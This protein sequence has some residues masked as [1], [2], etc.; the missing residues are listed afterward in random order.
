MILKKIKISEFIKDNSFYSSCLVP[1]FPEDIEVYKK[2]Q[3]NVLLEVD[4]KQPRN[5]LL[6]RKFFKLC[7]IFIDNG[8]IDKLLTSYNIENSSFFLKR[9]TDELYKFLKW[10]ILPHEILQT[11]LGNIEI[12]SSI[13]FEKMDNIQFTTFFD[14]SIEILSSVLNISVQDFLDNIS[15]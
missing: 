6:H 13:S 3:L 11:P 15:L 2:I 10:I 4:V 9:D 1:V 5:L 12:W 7:K 14:K 8:G